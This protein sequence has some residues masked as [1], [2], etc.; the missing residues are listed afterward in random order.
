MTARKSVIIVGGGSGVRMGGDLPKQFLSLAGKPVIFHTLLKF[1]KYDP[2]I[3]VLMV[4]P[5]AARELWLSICRKENLP[6]DYEIVN[7]GSERFYSVK[8]AL[9]RD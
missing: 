3:K 9:E 5:E 7:G 6:V 4:L 1:R 2:S 8:Y